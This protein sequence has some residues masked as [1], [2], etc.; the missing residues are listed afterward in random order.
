MPPPTPFGGGPT[1]RRTRAP[2]GPPVSWRWDCGSDG[3]RSRHPAHPPLTRLVAPRRGD[4]DSPVVW[5]PRGHSQG[6]SLAVRPHHER[7]RGRWNTIDPGQTQFRTTSPRSGRQYGFVQISESPGSEAPEAKRPAGSFP[8]PVVEVGLG[9]GR[10]DAATRARDLRRM[11]RFATGLLL[12]ATV[13]FLVSRWWEVN[14]GPAWLG[15]VRATAEAGMV[16]ALADWFAVTAL[17]RRPLGLPIP[18]TAIIPTR[19]DAIGDASASSSGTNFLSEDVVREKLGRARCRAGSATGSATA[20]AERVT[21]ELATAVRGII[22]VLRDEDMRTCSSRPVPKIAGDPDRPAARPVLEGVSDDGAHQRLVDLVSSARY[23]WIA[24]NHDL[25]SQVVH[26]RAPSWSPR[27][28]DELVADRVYNEVLAFARAV[29]DRPRAPAAQGGRPVPRRVR[30]RPAERPGDH[31]A[32]RA[33]QGP[34]R[35]HPEV[36]TFSAR[37]G[38]R[39]RG[40][41]ATPPTTRR[42]RCASGCATGSSQLGT[43]LSTDDGAARQGR[44][45]GRGR[46]RLHRAPLPRARSPR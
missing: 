28:V 38:A 12:L 22:T 43:R 24:D 5:R 34:D 17:F 44:R 1:V 35:Q 14:D 39:S 2:S 42:A 40:C 32:G 36:R 26:E 9:F 27:F 30:H 3:P 6:G 31:R 4:P 25:V 37:P 21:A 18:H 11:K 8:R 29:Q 16:G 46:G 15:Y 41:P 10:I 20:N 19:K 13:I 45:L 33:D 7:G 23:E